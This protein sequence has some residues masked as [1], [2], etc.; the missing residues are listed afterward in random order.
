MGQWQDINLE[1]GHNKEKTVHFTTP[2]KNLLYFL[3]SKES[4]H[5]KQHQLESILNKTSDLD[6]EGLEP[7]CKRKKGKFLTD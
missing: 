4:C 7:V 3:G 2:F 6:A 5:K 1:G